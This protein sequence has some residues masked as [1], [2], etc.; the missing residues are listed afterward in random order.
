MKKN[1]FKKILISFFIFFFLILP[2]APVG[3]VNLSDW[4]AMLGGVGF[5]AGYNTGQSDPIA[6]AGTIIKLLLSLLGVVFLALMIFGGFKW[7][8]AQGN[9]T[10][11][12][13]AK[14]LIK[15][16]II[17][18]VIVFAAYAISY[19]VVEALTKTTINL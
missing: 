16:A 11:V 15:A 19:F 10:Q 5:D 4:D 9:E 12:S 13:D 7:M 8:M 1:K 14:N 17:G 2:L 18:I 3:A 6:L